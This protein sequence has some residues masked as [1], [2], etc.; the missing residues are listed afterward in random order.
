MI[1]IPDVS[2]LAGNKVAHTIEKESKKSAR[3]II[4]WMILCMIISVILGYIIQVYL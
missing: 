2:T 3:I 1:K 4:I